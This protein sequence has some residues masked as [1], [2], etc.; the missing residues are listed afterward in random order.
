MDVVQFLTELLGDAVRRRS[1]DIHLEPFP[2]FMCVRQRVD[3]FLL[4]THRVPV[5]H[6]PALLSRIK[7]MS[8]LDLGERRLPQDGAMTIHL[9]E[10]AAEVRVSLLPTLYGEKAVLR[11]LQTK[12]E[13]IQLHHLGMDPEELG[14]LEQ[15]LQRY[16]GLVIVTGPTGSGK[17][18]SLYAM[19]QCLNDS[20]R[21][22][23]TLEDPVEV[24]IP[25]INQVQV[26]PKAGMNFSVGLRAILRQDPDVIMIGEIRDLETAEIA[27]RAALT[28]HLVLTTL[29][30]SDAIGAV[31][32]LMDMGIEPYRVANALSGVVAQRLIRKGCLYCQ[33]SGCQE[34]HHTG[35]YGRT[36]VF[37]VLEVDDDFRRLI[38]ESRT[39]Q[40]YRNHFRQKG[41]RFLPEGFRRKVSSGITTYDEML[42]VMN[43]V[44]EVQLDL[45]STNRIPQ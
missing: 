10:M 17:S 16:T 12:K 9:D 3:G 30:T 15:I 14:R 28:G 13:L 1:S 4:E 23:I 7:V 19:L 24:Q 20:A 39:I 26:H 18:T 29:H 6:A 32:R 40:R 42:R 34:C 31:V 5:E 41:I 33:A 43:D 35:Y 25:G 22:V 27:I 11:L 2:D 44:A 36:G 45:Q 8:Q 38:I 21:N 37:E